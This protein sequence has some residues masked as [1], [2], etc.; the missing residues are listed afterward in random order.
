M[1]Q[2]SVILLASALLVLSASAAYAAQAGAP[3]PVT[4]DE[5][6]SRAFDGNGQLIVLTG[7]AIG[8]ALNA[9]GG[10]VWV[11]VLGGTAIGAVV[12]RDMAG[13]IG[14]WGD[15]HN[16][17]DTVHVTGVFNVACDEH[18]GDMDVHATALKVIDAGFPRAHPADW[19]KG[20]IGLVGLVVAVLAVLRGRRIRAEQ[21]GT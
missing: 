5:L 6:T 4:I 2:A 16:T 14:T 21:E 15:Y 10:Q 18:G 13:I 20:L 12:D 8:E 1:K 7:E 19:R 11:N 9:P 17:G 3:V